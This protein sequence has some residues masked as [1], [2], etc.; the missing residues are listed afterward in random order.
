MY[1]LDAKK[2]K[3]KRMFFLSK[4]NRSQMNKTVTIRKG[5][6]FQDT[7][8]VYLSGSNVHDKLTS[9]DVQMHYSL[10]NE[11]SGAFRSSRVRRDQLRPVLGQFQKMAAHSITIQKN[12]GQDN[13]CI[14]D[15]SVEASHA[16]VYVIGSKEKLE[17]TAQIVNTGEDAFNAMLYLR[18]PE[19]VNYIG[20][21]SSDTAV[22]VLCSPP[23]KVFFCQ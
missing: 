3:T 6:T 1:V 13:L 20:A 2:D 17:I 21:N 18:V 15:L 14:P 12:C 5:S 8:T 16:G 19:G 22:T 9:L 23:T 7:H 10:R 11:G 4:E